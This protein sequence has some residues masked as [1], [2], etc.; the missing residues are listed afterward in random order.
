[1]STTTITPTLAKNEEHNYRTA[2]MSDSLGHEVCGAV[3]G[4][5]KVRAMAHA[6]AAAPSP[7]IRRTNPTP[8]KS[9]NSPAARSTSG[10]KSRC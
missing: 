6:L 9:G 2:E 10:G 4:L 1:M 3:H 5:E 7:T 8:T